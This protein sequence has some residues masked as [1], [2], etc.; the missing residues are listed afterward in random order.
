MMTMLL[1][2]TAMSARATFT[3]CYLYRHDVSDLT[4][5]YN[6][7]VARIAAHTR[8]IQDLDIDLKSN[9][10][11]NF[12][13]SRNFTATFHSLVVD[14]QCNLI[15][16]TSAFFLSLVAD[17]FAPKYPN[18]MF[19]A[20]VTD[21]LPVDFPTNFAYFTVS[22]HQGLFRAG[23][24]ASR[25]VSDQSCIGFIAT[26]LTR[27]WEPNAF[28][29]G[30]VW[31]NR[32][33]R[34]S[35]L[36]V[37]LEEDTSADAEMAAA[38]LMVTKGCE[39]IISVTTNNVLP[40]YVA[41]AYPNV[42]TI[43]YAADSALTAGDSVL[44]S[45][46]SDLQ[47]FF[48]NLTIDAINATMPRMYS[49]NMSTEIL[50]AELSPRSSVSLVAVADLAKGFA[51]S[52]DVSCGSFT[53]RNGV[54]H[55]HL[56]VNSSNRNQ[57]PY[58]D[59]RITFMP[60]FRSP[61]FC[62]EGYYAS[63]DP[64]TLA[65]ACLVCPAN[66]Y[67]PT[68]GLIACQP[69]EDGLTA[70]EGS[71]GCTVP[72]NSSFELLLIIPIVVGTLAVLIVTGAVTASLLRVRVASS[73]DPRNAPPGP[74]VALAM[75][76]V[77]GARSDRHWRHSL[78]NMCDVYDQLA[79]II[80]SV[81]NEHKGY[82]FLSVGDVFMLAMK[83]PTDLVQL[84]G[85][86]HERASRASWPC[87]IRLKIAL[88]YG[89]P[90]IGES[91][92]RK[93]AGGDDD[94]R[95]TYTGAEVDILRA[96]WKKEVEETCDVVLSDKAREHLEKGKGHHDVAGHDVVLYNL[97]DPTPF[98]SDDGKFLLQASEL[99][100][101]VREQSPVE[102]GTSATSMT[103]P[104]SVG[105]PQ[106]DA[107]NNAGDND[108]RSGATPSETSETV[109]DDLTR[110]VT[111]SAISKEELDALRSLGVDLLQKF[112]RV[113]SFDDQ[114]SIVTAIA[115]KLHVQSPQIPEM[116]TSAKKSFNV[117]RNSL[118]QICSQLLLSMDEMELH[119]WLD[120]V[121]AHVDDGRPAG[122]DTQASRAPL[123]S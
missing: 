50:L 23:A 11:P 54:Y 33:S 78:T 115:K 111:P 90:N 102:G 59:S 6:F 110:L 77:D 70:T 123:H 42:S 98:T 60:A 17:T 88:H 28:Y 101:E 93:V 106:F 97:R 48:Y 18:V 40:S 38:D 79:A 43:G 76:G 37:S 7:N 74:Y 75:L 56:C 114:V 68:A 112:I 80:S 89:T 3:S 105:A 35:L 26:R 55:A 109:D 31:A 20:R 47:Y 9:A 116:K 100:F 107:A 24:V 95:K 21:D 92:S 64:T 44:S 25:Y 46:Y 39:V 122:E 58:L 63:Y 99:C 32:T 30:M 120:G 8:L 108:A 94:K 36:A 41:N 19:A 49:L 104:L 121:A 85:H 10:Y 4:Y 118:R 96:M 117:L 61:I 22:M 73:L 13:Q 66:T 72:S 119:S 81:A 69:C 52:V 67:T 103:N 29:S 87:V 16:A 86:V 14:D 12:D 5:T 113:F 91:Q 83:E 82:I 62:R 27:S 57:Y 71:S 53:D 51:D 84:L 65:L 2:L 15:V 34:V 45:V 1:S